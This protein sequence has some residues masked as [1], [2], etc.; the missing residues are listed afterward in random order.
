MIETPENMLKRRSTGKFDADLRHPAADVFFDVF[1]KAEMTSEL[2]PTHVYSKTEK[3]RFDGEKG[4]FHIVHHGAFALHFEDANTPTHLCTGD[5][6]FIP[7]GVSHWIQYQATASTPGGSITSGL[8][9]FDCIGGKALM[10]GL[11][12]VL[13]VSS[14]PSTEPDTLGSREWLNLTVQAMQKEQAFPSIG[15]KIM[16]SRIIDLMFIWAIRNWLSTAPDSFTGWISA[17]RDPIVGHALALLHAEP[18]ADWTV[19][20]LATRIGQSRSNLANKFSRLIGE[21]PM[22][23]LVRWRMQLA[24]KRLR[25]SSQRI[26]TI[27]EGLGYDSDAAFSRAFR[28]ELGLTP[29]E[30]RQKATQ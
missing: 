3:Q 15:S 22:R 2:L 13:H 11:P 7:S 8:Y 23:Y 17:L 25:S 14:Q 24:V 30:Y 12:K 9:R 4:C 1:S 26:S 6:I 18:G 29:T 19:E 20:K 10:S 27:A 16:L 21:S 5:I 28:R